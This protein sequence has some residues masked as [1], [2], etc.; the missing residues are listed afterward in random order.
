[1]PEGHVIRRYA[2]RHRRA[3][4]GK[5]IEVSSPQGRFA[6]GADRLDG[7]MMLDVDAHGKH[8]FYRW[9]RAETLHVH[10]G[11]Y[12]KFKLYRNDPPPPTPGTRL[13]LA[14]E[15]ITVYLAGPTVCELITPSQEDAILDRLGPDPLKAGT[16]GNTAQD[17]ARNLSRRRIAI[18]AAVL[19][20]SVVAGI[21][22]IYRA[23]SLFLTRIHPRTPA[24]EVPPAKVLELWDKSVEL[25]ES[26]VAEGRIATLPRVPPGAGKETDR[27]YVYN[28]ERFP[29]RACGGPISTEEMAARSI[30][31]CD[32]C[33][34]A[35]DQHS[36]NPA[37]D[38]TT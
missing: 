26:G 30:W 34:P 1:M 31:W 10:L 27:L 12:G 38:S 7:R 25:L 24:N 5:R 14:A 37:P 21:G 9:Q 15:N 16:A 13:A 22:N 35:T 20:Q 23:E 6:A 17:F 29:C 3:L 19:D 36:A 11:L 18:G 33:Q 4:A 28:R 2:D 32:T 8:L